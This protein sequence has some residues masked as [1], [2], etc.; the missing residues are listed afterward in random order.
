MHVFASQPRSDASC[1][2]MNAHTS[3]TNHRR[4]ALSIPSASSSS[5][6][7]T[8]SSPRSSAACLTPVS[9]RGDLTPLFRH[10]G[11]PH[12]PLTPASSLKHNINNNNKRAASR[13]CDRAGLPP[14]PLFLYVDTHQPRPT[15]HLS[16]DMAASSS[17]RAPSPTR[18]SRALSV[19]RP[20]L[21]RPPSRC[22]SLLRDTLRKDQVERINPRRSLSR[23]R[24]RPSRPRGSSFLASLKGDSSDCE[25][26]D[27]LFARPSSEHG[28]CDFHRAMASAPRAV[29]SA[30]HSR[31]G[32][33]EAVA[34]P[35]GSPQ[36]PSPMPP[37][38]QRTRTAPAVPR[39]GAVGKR[40]YGGDEEHQVLATRPPPVERRSLPNTVPQ[41]HSAS[42]E[43]SPKLR[44]NSLNSPQGSVLLKSRVES[45]LES[46]LIEDKRVGRARNHQRAYSHGVTVN[47]SAQRHPDD[48]SPGSPSPQVCFINSSH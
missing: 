11:S 17:S 21:P 13:H 33:G 14:P 34:H 8:A 36:S 15:S 27:C 24:P 18:Q 37:S 44:Q 16:K 38:I 29:S 47:T 41:S 12:R 43:S 31:Q 40:P 25:L 48:P 2:T 20:E 28:A 22:E 4:D 30:A 9:S 7:T 26:D 39:I 19:T 46:L 23:S 1:L 5:S 6:F 35:Y 32:S 45:K 10:K 42:T 3:N